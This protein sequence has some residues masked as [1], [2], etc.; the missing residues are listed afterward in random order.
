MQSEET[1]MEIKALFRLGLQVTQIAREYNL[2]R[3]T[4]YKRN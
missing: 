4:V 3:T 1:R 2:S